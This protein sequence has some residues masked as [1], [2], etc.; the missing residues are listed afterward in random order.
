MA[1]DVVGHFSVAMSVGIVVVLLGAWS[2]PEEV[3]E[4][5]SSPEVA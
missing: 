2:S 3:D 1:D 5:P 4:L